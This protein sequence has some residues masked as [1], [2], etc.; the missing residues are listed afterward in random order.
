MAAANSRTLSR[1]VRRRRAGQ[2][3]VGMAFSAAVT[4]RG[5]RR[6]AEAGPQAVADA[7]LG[8]DHVVAAQLGELGPQV[9][10]VA[11]DGA[12]GDGEARPMQALDDRVAAE[13][14]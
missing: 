5:S 7:G 14:L 11:V 12:V 4:V 2:W 8:L 13:H 10:H 1:M 9:A 3:G 6:R